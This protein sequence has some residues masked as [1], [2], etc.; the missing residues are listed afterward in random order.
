MA[1]PRAAAHARANADLLQLLTTEH[2]ALQTARAATVAEANGRTTLFMNTVAATVV[3]TAFVGQAN[4]G[5]VSLAGFLLVVLPVLLFLGLVTF[6][7]LL[8]T[9]MYDMSYAERIN[10]LR[11]FYLEIAPEFGPVLTAPLAEDPMQLPLLLRGG[12]F[13]WRSLLSSAGVVEVVNGGLAAV[14][15]G[16]LTANQVGA[17]GVDTIA[18]GGATFFVVLT[19]QL[20]YQN[21]RWRRARQLTDENR[22]QVDEVPPDGCHLGTEHARRGSAG[23]AA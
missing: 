2:F 16:V 21:A 7:R 17:P 23:R 8:D 14:F 20:L 10:R 13:W 19:V 6:V 4:P 5:G 9:S 22:A 1:N 3:A 18:V 11:A 15:A 12:P